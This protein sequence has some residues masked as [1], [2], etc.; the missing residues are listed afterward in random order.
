MLSELLNEEYSHCKDSD[1]AASS[2]L[3]VFLVVVYR[4]GCKNILGSRIFGRY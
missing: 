2:L 1:L 4:D 3:L